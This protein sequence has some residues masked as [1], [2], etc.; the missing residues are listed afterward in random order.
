MATTAHIALLGFSATERD[1]FA[2]F[3]RIAGKRRPAYAHEAH[4]EAADFVIFDA[5]DVSA[6]AQVRAGAWLP[7]AVALGEPVCRGVMLQLPRPLNLILLV[8]SLDEVIARRGTAAEFTDSVPADPTLL[9]DAERRRALAAD[10]I[11][12]AMAD[13]LPAPLE[14]VAAVPTPAP[15]GLGRRGRKRRAALDHILVVDDSDVAL[16][17]MAGHLQRFGFQIHLARSGEEALRRVAQRHFEFVFMDVMM[18]GLD[19]FQACKAIKRA[20]YPASKKPPT[21]VMLTARGTAADKLRGTMA[22]ADAYLTKPLSES[23][24]L[25][26]VGDREIQ[27]HAY[28]STAAALT[29]Q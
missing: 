1:T 29:T 27:R 19:G 26:V 12:R 7:R 24:L 15:A 8:R 14:A 28:A 13:T 25:K 20:T 3:F 23:E 2:A 9:S 5:A 18:E 22:G 11:A 17:F 21:V 4:A 16:R 10:T 6:V